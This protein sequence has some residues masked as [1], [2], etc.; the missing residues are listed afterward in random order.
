MQTLVIID[1]QNEFSPDGRRAVPDHASAIAAIQRRIDAARAND[2]PIAWVRHHNLPHEW[3]AFE[4]GS[5]G[6]DYT[7]GFGPAPDRPQEREFVKTVL[8]AFTGSELGAWLTE[9]GSD[10]V[11]IAGFYTHMCVSTTAR[12]ALMRD[13]RVSIDPDGTRAPALDHPLLGSLSA[14]EARRSALLHLHDLGVNLTP[15]SG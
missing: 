15:Y 12:E 11:L 13:L 6:A 9:I 5:W 1:A 8:G 2:F 7:S 14:E 3:P 4:P 10:D